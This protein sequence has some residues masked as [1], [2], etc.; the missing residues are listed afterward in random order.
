MRP[1]LNNTTLKRYQNTIL[2]IRKNC[3]GTDSTTRNIRMSG[4]E[5]D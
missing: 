2:H 5:P 4:T 3:Y 1:K